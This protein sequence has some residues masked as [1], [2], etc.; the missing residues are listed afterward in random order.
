MNV[1]VSLLCV[2]TVVVSSTAG[3][4]KVNNS[5]V[6]TLADEPRGDLRP[7]NG[8][9]A[10]GAWNRRVTTTRSTMEDRIYFRGPPVSGAGSASDQKCRWWLGK[11]ILMSR[12]ARI[13]VLFW[14]RAQIAISYVRNNRLWLKSTQ[15]PLSFFSSV[16]RR[17]SYSVLVID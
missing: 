8:P 13:R 3:D 5:I 15:N 10:A 14:A 4:R 11:R 6:I 12:T 2:L 7:L 17:A 16:L 9:A 1:V